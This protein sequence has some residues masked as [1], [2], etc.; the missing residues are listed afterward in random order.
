M[1]D[2]SADYAADAVEAI[3]YRDA[4]EK[5]AASVCEDIGDQDI[6]FTLRNLRRLGVRPSCVPCGDR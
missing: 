5:S 2:L 1:L 6:R 4:T 3:S